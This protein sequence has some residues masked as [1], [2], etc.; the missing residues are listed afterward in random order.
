MNEYFKLEGHKAVPC[1]LMTWAG[2]MEN[3]GSRRVAETAIG[4]ARVSTVFLG[5]DHSFGE[6][7]LQL[8]ETMAF[9]LPV[10]REEQ[11]ERCATWEQAEK[12]HEKMCEYV[13]GVANP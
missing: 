11:M 3:I 13:R 12:Q 8:F 4:Q 9:G 2:Q 5:L 1:D 7:P 6:G 10:E